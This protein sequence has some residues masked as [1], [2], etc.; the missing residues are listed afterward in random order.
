MNSLELKPCPFC[1]SST[2]P[3]IRQGGP[4]PVYWVLCWSCYV[5]TDDG[6]SPKEAAAAWNRREPLKE[7][8]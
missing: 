1:G 7:A 8:K 4:A 5:Q 3:E 2:A 6:E